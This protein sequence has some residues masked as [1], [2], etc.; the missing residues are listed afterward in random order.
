M[1]ELGQLE[2]NHE[3]FAKRGIQIYAIANDKEADAKEVQNQFPH[4]IIVS[5]AEQNVAK[6][7][8]VIHAG[9]APDGTDTNA[10]T[11][12]FVDGAGNVRWMFRPSRI[13]DRL[14]PEQLL[15]A[16]DESSPKTR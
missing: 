8:Q 12:F 2:S 4:L 5:D 13:T 6:A 10:P 16:I 15:N 7:M 14:S 1:L 11:T 3:A 9:E